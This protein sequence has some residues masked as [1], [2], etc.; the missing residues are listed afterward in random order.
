[1]AASEGH[2]ATV[3]RDLGRLGAAKLAAAMMQPGFVVAPQRVTAFVREQPTAQMFQSRPLFEGQGH[4]SLKG[5]QVAGRH[6]RLLSK[7]RWGEPGYIYALVVVHVWRH[8][9]MAPTTKDLR[10]PTVLI[11]WRAMLAA[12]GNRRPRVLD[13]GVGRY[14]GGVFDTALN[15]E[16][17]IHIH[18]DP[19]HTVSLAGFGNCPAQA[20]HG[21]RDD[22][23]GS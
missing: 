20:G 19:R 2:L 21:Q 6:H 23:D 16:G 13:T 15:A 10:A 5:Q 7:G 18:R 3:W 4:C 17:H 9:A 22:G 11:A 14:F 8:M 1:M 12:F